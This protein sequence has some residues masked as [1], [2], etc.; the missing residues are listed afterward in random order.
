MAGGRRSAVIAG[1]SRHGTIGTRAVGGRLRTRGACEQGSEDYSTGETQTFD[2]KT[3]LSGKVTFDIGNRRF[4]IGQYLGAVAHHP[5]RAVGETE[6]AERDHELAE[7]VPRVKYF[8]RR[9]ERGLA[10]IH[11]QQ[12]RLA[13][14]LQ[15][16]LDD[17]VGGIDLAVAEISPHRIEQY[18]PARESLA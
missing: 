5:R 10:V 13:H 16:E 4:E 11:Q 1:A 7:I 18:E 2:H 14:I 15:I 8:H 17:F 3:L 9:A 6:R 12:V